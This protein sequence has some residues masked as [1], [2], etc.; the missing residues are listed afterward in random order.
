M[1]QL[2]RCVGCKQVRP[3]FRIC[4]TC[5]PDNNP[6]CVKCFTKKINAESEEEEGETNEE[7][8]KEKKKDNKIMNSRVTHISGME[9]DDHNDADQSVSKA[10]GHVNP[11]FKEFRETAI[12]SFPH[13]SPDDYPMTN[14]RRQS[15][16]YFDN[17]GKIETPVFGWST[18]GIDR[19]V[20]F[21]KDQFIF[22]RYKEGDTLIYYNIN[23]STWADNHE[24]ANDDDLIRWYTDIEE[25][26]ER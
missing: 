17:K 11:T 2:R 10:F 9:R 14:V 8:N 4:G 6:L 15:V 22:Q 21:I 16:G 7:T 23:D 1:D 5:P 18:D 12:E 25:Y 13:L 3:I 19:I 20:L 26:L 24:M